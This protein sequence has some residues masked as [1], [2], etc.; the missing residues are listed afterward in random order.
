MSSRQLSFS[1]VQPFEMTVTYSEAVSAEPLKHPQAHAHTQCEIYI[2]L[3]GDVSFMV[4]DTI[5]PIAPG[6]VIITR[7]HEYHR[8]IY[9]RETRHRH[10][11]IL[12]SAGGNE[13]LLDLFFD[14][15]AGQNNDITLDEFALQ[16]VEQ[17]CHR[18]MDTEDGDPTKWYLFFRLLELLRAGRATENPALPIGVPEDVRIAIA[19]IH[20]HQTEPILV[21]DL[22]EAAHVSVNTLERHFAAM[23]RTSPLGFVKQKRLTRALHLLDGGASVSQACFESGF[24]DYSHFI[25]TFKQYYGLTPLQYKKKIGAES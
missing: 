12:F 8:C 25:A 4:E 1:A 18:L 23:M 14:R 5:Y 3:S 24:A 15:P 9:H 22:A 7:P 19:Y 17:L 6:R 21:R 11:W 20:A 10:F 16:E 2:N 13:P